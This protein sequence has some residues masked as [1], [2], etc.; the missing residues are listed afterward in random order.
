M[1]KDIFID[2]NI[3]CRFSNPIA[4]EIKKLLDWLMKYEQDSKENAMLMVSQKLKHEYM[5]SCRGTYGRTSIPVI[6][7]KLTREGRLVN[8]SNE[9]IKTFKNKYFTKA[10][11]K[12]LRSNNEDRNHIPVVLLSERKYALT[13]DTNFT[14]D[15]ENFPGF[16]VLVSSRPENIPYDK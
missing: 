4:P 5:A 16:K 13:K 12:K 2:N 6:M 1:R 7:D 15:L 3:A 9:D 14:Y 11:E 10:V 8:V